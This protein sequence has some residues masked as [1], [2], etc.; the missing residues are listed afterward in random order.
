MTD[1][2]NA[3]AP[4]F[5]AWQKAW[6]SKP[7]SEMLGYVHGLGARPGKQAL[8]IA[9]GLRPEGVSNSQIV[10]ACGNPQLN[11][12][13]GYI[14]DAYVKRD[15]TA[16]ANSMGHTVYKL[17]YTKKG[18]ARVE[19]AQA[20]AAKLEAAGATSEAVKPGK[21]VKKAAGTKKARKPTAAKLPKV[22]PVD[23]NTG[24]PAAQANDTPRA[25]LPNAFTEQPQG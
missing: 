12:M 17:E 25:E 6:G 9:M 7:T 16:P 23:E 5:K 8:A 3:Y 19:R 13:R 2:T 21:A 15:M 22:S 1:H 24:E 4:V 18:L 14:S 11:K 20:Q 10:G